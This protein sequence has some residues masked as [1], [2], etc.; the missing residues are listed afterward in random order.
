MVGLD[1]KVSDK[2]IWPQL[3]QGSDYRKGLPLYVML[4]DFCNADGYSK[5]CP[6][7]S[8]KG[9]KWSVLRTGKLSA[10]S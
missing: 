3:F 5:E 2:Q 10:V 7:A 1:N 9:A 4:S 6:G 8:P